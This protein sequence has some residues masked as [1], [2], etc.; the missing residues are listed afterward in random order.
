MVAPANPITREVRL[1]MMRPGRLL[2]RFL[3]DEEGPTAVEYGVMMALIIVV[4][5][6]SITTLGTNSNKTYQAVAAQAGKSTGS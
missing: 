3:R 2:V 6:V 5:L 1:P 4:C